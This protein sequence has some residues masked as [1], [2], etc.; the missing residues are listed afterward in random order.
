MK[1]LI[2]ILL[3]VLA[4]AVFTGCNTEAPG[5]E[6]LITEFGFKD[7]SPVTAEITG[8]AIEVTVPYGTDLTSLIATFT[9]TGVSVTVDGTPQESGVT[10]N[11]FTS[12]VTYSVTAEDGSSYDF[13][14]IVTAE[15][16]SAKDFISFVFKADDNDSLSSNI[17]GRIDGS[18]IT[19]KVPYGTDKTALV[20]DFVTTGKYVSVNFVEQSAGVTGNDFSGTIEYTVTAIDG[21]YQVY[22]I[23]VLMTVTRAQLDALIT[24]EADVT[25]LDTSDITDMSSLFLNNSSF[26]QD[27]SGW[28]V[29]NVTDMSGMFHGAIGF[30][31]DISAWDVGNVLD[32]SFM[33]ASD[34][35]K[36]ITF[37]QDI[38]GWDVSKVTNMNFMFQYNR[39]FTYDISGW[40]VGSVTQWTG[41]NVLSYIAADHIPPKFR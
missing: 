2:Y 13:A 19:L 35:D 36:F 18:T 23:E 4:L 11:D 28:D 41:F 16:N 25:R 15:L 40:D 37:N 10:A 3:A 22:S 33:F 29:S 7:V 17:I 30:D 39:H 5:A 9:S 20:A 6:L 26:N 34:Y 1:K 12:P 24:A 27:I 38:S 14:V 31:Q 8:V 21:S 32:M